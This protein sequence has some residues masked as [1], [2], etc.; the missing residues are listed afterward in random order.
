MTELEAAAELEYLMKKRGRGF[1]L[2]TRS[3]LPV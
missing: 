2:L 3:S 1:K